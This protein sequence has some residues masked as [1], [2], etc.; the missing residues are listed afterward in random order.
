[1][2]SKESL[3]SQDGHAG[4][5]PVERNP[6]FKPRLFNTKLSN[7]IQLKKAKTMKGRRLQRGVD[8]IS[9][10]EERTKLKGR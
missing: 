7:S 10:E 2:E 6:K 1:M 4:I 5:M 3:L 9:D 8:D